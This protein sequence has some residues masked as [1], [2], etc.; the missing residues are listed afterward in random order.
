[1]PGHL[2]VK[3]FG[4]GKSASAARAE[5]SLS[6]PASQTILTAQEQEFF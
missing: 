5:C 1:M 2:F 3:P 6:L 4:K